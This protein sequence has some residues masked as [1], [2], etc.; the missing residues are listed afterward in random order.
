MQIYNCKN[1]LEKLL[2][3]LEFFGLTRP[4]GSALFVLNE[5]TAIKWELKKRSIDTISQLIESVRP[6]TSVLL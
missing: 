6:L 4:H 3:I 1:L 2:L 5:Q